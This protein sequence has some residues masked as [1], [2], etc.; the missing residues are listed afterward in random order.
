MAALTR[1]GWPERMGL[2]PGTVLTVTALPLRP[3][4][5]IDE[6]LAGAPEEYLEAARAGR[7]VRGLEAT[8]AD[9]TTRPLGSTD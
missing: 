1:D 2:G 3:T 4:A 7:F 5:A 8:L 6:V 9:G